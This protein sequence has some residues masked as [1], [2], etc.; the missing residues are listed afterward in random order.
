M[1][2]IYAGLFLLSS[3][4]VALA[5]GPDMP[6]IEPQI[7]PEVIEQDTASSGSQD[8]LVPV[9]ALIMFGVALSK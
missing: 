4:S 1:K 2:T 3:A 9:M 7:T 8:I 5:G 6:V